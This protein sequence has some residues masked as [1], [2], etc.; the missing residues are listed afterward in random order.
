MRRKFNPWVR[1]ISW[2]RKRQYIPV[3]SPGKSHGER[4]LAG[5]SPWG[6]KGL[7]MTEHTHTGSSFIICPDLCRYVVVVHLCLTLC[8]PMDC[9]PPG[10]SLHGISQERLLEW[11]AISSSRGSSQPRDWTCISCVSCRG[12]VPLSSGHLTFPLGLAT[13]RFPNTTEYQACLSC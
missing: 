8:D 12:I 7:D 11:V 4:N 9:S 10:C 3:F 2:R 13:V 5:Y 6:H 1:K